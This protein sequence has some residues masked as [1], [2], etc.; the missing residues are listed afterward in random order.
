MVDLD[1]PSDSISFSLDT[2][3]N[4]CFFLVSLLVFSYASPHRDV[5]GSLGFLGQALD[6]DVAIEAWCGTTTSFNVSDKR[7]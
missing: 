5:R 3:C 2:R 6:G 7:I 4:T 1:T